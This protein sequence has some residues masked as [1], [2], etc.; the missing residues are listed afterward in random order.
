MRALR[1][2]RVV[3][4]IS[5]SIVVAL[6]ILTSYWLMPHRRHRPVEPRVSQKPL[7]P[8]DLAMLRDRFTAALDAFHHNYG[9]TAAQ[10]LVSFVLGTRAVEEYRIYYLAK[11]KVIV[12]R[13]I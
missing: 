7:A 5:I 11:V 12:K 9:A 6:L 8:P 10:Q 1:R 3:L 4:G 13:V 2:P